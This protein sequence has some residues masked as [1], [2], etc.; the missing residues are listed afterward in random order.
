MTRRT[1]LAAALSVAALT[2]PAFAQSTFPD[3]PVQLIAPYAP[4]GA[5]D[6]LSRLLAKEMET[7][8]GKPVIVVNKP[9]GG[10]VVGVQALLAAPADGYTMFISSNST[11]TLN[12][13]VL[14]KP[15]YDATKDFE[16][17]AQVATIGLTIVT[18]ADHP[19][20]DIAGLVAS[21][22]AE[23]DKV[24]LA[25]F[26]NATTSH[27]AGEW[28]KS[29]AGIKMVHVAYRGSGPAMNDL[30]GKHIPF[31]VDTIVAAKP[32]I[33]AG[34][35]RPLAVTSARRSV[36][37]PEV[38]TLQELGHKDVDLS[39]WVTLVVARGTPA[40]AKAKLAA[41]L[42]KVMNDPAVKERMLKTGFEP[43]YAK[44]ADWPGQI[45]KEIAAMKAIA[46]S[47]NIKG[48]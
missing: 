14:E 28:F 22:K 3:K 37:L 29:V 38:P 15:P 31:L 32:Q 34:K 47:A 33:E 10:T 21:A 26:G 8:L 13:A 11:F 18:H 9:G 42:D 27:F 1:L 36:M 46:Q 48:D 45:G 5:A 35:I 19:V 7:Q 20:K 12:P 4:G 39:S 30:V 40:D 23:P 6:V 17:L 24:T 41:A 25:S 43:A 44:Y 16:P 2:M